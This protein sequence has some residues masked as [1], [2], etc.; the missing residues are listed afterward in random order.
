[1]H[2]SE[3]PGMNIKTIPLMV[4]AGLFVTVPL[5]WA[6]SVDE[7][8]CVSP[9]SPFRD[10]MSHQSPAMQKDKFLHLYKEAECLRKLTEAQGAEWLETE[11]L[12]LAS[13]EQADEN[14]WNAANL[15]VEE[16][17]FQSIAALRQAKYEA[18]AWKH[19]VVD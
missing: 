10:G 9:D 13:Q 1:V 19:R 18:E 12:L 6:D 14:H 7:T 17:L 2:V 15:L 16:A 8:G 3:F 11:G 5:A 4:I